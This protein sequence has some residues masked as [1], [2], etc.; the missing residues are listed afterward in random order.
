MTENT[1]V[2]RYAAGWNDEFL[3]SWLA[4]GTWRDSSKPVHERAIASAAATPLGT[5]IPLMT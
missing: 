5:M 3:R 2:L 1:H 4:D